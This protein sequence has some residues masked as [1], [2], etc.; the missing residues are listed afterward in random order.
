MIVR[1]LLLGALAEVA[2][3]AAMHRFGGYYR[4]APNM[5]VHFAIDRDALPDL[6]PVSRVY[7]NADG[8]RGGPAPRP[9]EHAYRAL[10]VGGS[11]AECALLD[12]DDT[13]A[14]VVERT[15][16][17]RGFAPRVHVGSVARAILPCRDLRLLLSKTLP[18]YRSLDLVLVMAG[19][20]DLVSWMEVGMPR[21][22]DPRPREIDK[23]FEQHPEG[24]WGVSPRQT[25]LYR[26]IGGLRRGLPPRVVQKTGGDWL[27]RVRRMRA[28]AAR[29]ID[30]EPDATPMLDGFASGLAGLIETARTRAKRVIVVRQ[31]WRYEVPLEEQSL[32]WNFGLGRPYR[33]DVSTYFTTR[34]VDAL[35]RK[36][37][38]RAVAV[39]EE[40]GVEQVDLM[41]RLAQSRE[42]FYDD[43]H[44]TPK[45]A[46]IVGRAV[47][48]AVMGEG[49]GGQSAAEERP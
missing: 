18:R 34:V 42:I 33:E 6:P 11:A 25:A 46:E 16:T 7:I 19:A 4:Y 5:R 32:L 8:E 23:I 21:E 15:L 43:L 31:P 17:E 22:I 49:R 10:V 38:A 27:H 9:E 1:A 36:V 29:W 24:P 37:D 30:E 48:E 3:R 28:G 20:A 41:P 2:A 45:G 12:Q 26:V 14:A 47:A 40:A 39:A 35:M 13:W 44:F